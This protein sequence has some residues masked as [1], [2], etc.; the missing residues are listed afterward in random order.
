MKY[1]VY[2]GEC[3][4]LYETQ[5]QAEAALTKYIDSAGEDYF[6]TAYMGEVTH[7]TKRTIVKI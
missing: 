7:T 4:E 1:F 2:D 6:P 5:E 3:F